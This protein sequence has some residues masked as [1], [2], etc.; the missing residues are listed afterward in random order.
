MRTTL[1]LDDD[2]AARLKVETHRTGRSFK[3]VVNDYLRQGLSSTAA[4]A[5]Q[6]QPT[7]RVIAR[8]LGELRPGL[9]LDKIQQL[10]DLAEGPLNR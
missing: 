3:T 7:F 10:L 4:A 9:S 8:D 2:V 6:Q 5:G 1:T